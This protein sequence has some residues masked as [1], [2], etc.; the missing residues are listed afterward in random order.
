[1]KKGLL[2]IVLVL[3]ML[4]IGFGT[5]SDDI[6]LP[7][8]NITIA[9]INKNI[10]KYGTGKKVPKTIFAIIKLKYAKTIFEVSNREIEDGYFYFEVKNQKEIDTINEYVEEFNKNEENNITIKG[11][12]NVYELEDGTKYL[13]F[14]A[15]IKTDRLLKSR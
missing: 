8:E 7:A 5:G 2:L 13:A 9:D 11:Y 15:Y 4:L 14:T 6:L 1:M 10:D 12:E 3:G